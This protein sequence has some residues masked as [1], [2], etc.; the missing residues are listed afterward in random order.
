MNNNDAENKGALSHIKDVFIG[1][2]YPPKWL[3]LSVICRGQ[4]HGVSSQEVPVPPLKSTVAL[5]YLFNFSEQKFPHLQSGTVS[6]GSQCQKDDVRQLM[7]GKNAI[8]DYYSYCEII[9]PSAKT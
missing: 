3:H 5:A 1:S 9:V 2:D 4:K 7:K 6:S 8:R